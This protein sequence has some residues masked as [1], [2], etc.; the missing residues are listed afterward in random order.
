MFT[1]TPAHR[2]VL[3]TN[4]TKPCLT[5][6]AEEVLLVYDWECPV[7]DIYCRLVRVRPTVGR[8]CLVNAR[9]STVALQEIT[10]AGL[11]I[12]QGMVVKMAGQLYCGSDAIQALALIS[13]R[14]DLFN[15][16][17]YY[18]FRSSRL[19]CVLYP[20]LRICRNLLLKVMGKTKINNL[21]IEGNACF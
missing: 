3:G 6:A 8:L 4:Y 17:I 18:I 14:T 13:D 1:M 15:R 20:A 7:C 2:A 10:R 19:S 5:K 21:K 12:D 16:L 9:E 11:D